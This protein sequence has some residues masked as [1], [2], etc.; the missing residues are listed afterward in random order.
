MFVSWYIAVM[1]IEFPGVIHSVWPF[2]CHLIVCSWLALFVP[3]TN[4]Q[5][6][7]P[8]YVIATCFLLITC[9]LPGNVFQLL[10]RDI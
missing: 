3:F 8:V 7:G 5:V 1:E 10:T 6:V 9:A 4:M 2:V